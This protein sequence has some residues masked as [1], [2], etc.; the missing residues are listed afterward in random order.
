MCD[1]EHRLLGFAILVGTGL[2]TLTTGFLAKDEGIGIVGS[3]LLMAA[4]LNACLCDRRPVYTTASATAYAT[5]YATA[6]APESIAH[7]A[8]SNRDTISVSTMYD[9]F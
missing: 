6:S 2:F 8:A 5:A 1:A 3:V 4:T 9:N 7:V